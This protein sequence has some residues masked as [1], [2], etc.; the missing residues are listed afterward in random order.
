MTDPIS[1]M[2]NRIKNA[3]AVGKSAVEFPFSK[4]KFEI[5]RILK[6]GGFIDDFSKKGKKVD[7]TIKISFKASGDNGQKILHFKRISKPGRRIYQGWKDFKLVKQG[8]GA[9]IVSTPKGMLGGKEARKQKVGG[10]IICEVW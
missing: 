1:D 7:K 3:Q 8:F 2:F 6:E 4:I 5:S 10:E 9:T